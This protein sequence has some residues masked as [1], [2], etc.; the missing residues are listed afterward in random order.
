MGDIVPGIGLTGGGESGDGCAGTSG[1]KGGVG[2]EGGVEG[3]EKGGGGG[4]RL[5]KNLLNHST[6]PS[7]CQCYISYCLG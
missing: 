3:S 7:F 4:H 5:V 2:A 6:F 1:A